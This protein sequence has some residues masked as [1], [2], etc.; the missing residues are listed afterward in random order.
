M[1]GCSSLADLNLGYCKK[2]TA[3][4]LAEFCAFPPPALQ[5]LSLNDTNLESLPLSITNLTNLETLNDQPIKTG[6]TISFEKSSFASVDAII[7]FLVKF[8][9]AV[10][11]L[12]FSGTKSLQ[13]I[14]DEI[15]KLQNLKDLNLRETGI[16]GIPDEISKLQNLQTLNLQSTLIKSE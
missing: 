9:P 12:D 2:L 8:N 16:T 1:D 4:S 14:P 5:K 11:S 13:T 6:K 10:E 3:E 7:A 15:G